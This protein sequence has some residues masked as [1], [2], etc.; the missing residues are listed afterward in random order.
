MEDTL[1][2]SD[3]Y[4]LPVPLTGPDFRELA[5]SQ[6]VATLLAS[7]SAERYLSSSFLNQRALVDSVAV[8]FHSVAFVLD[9]PSLRDAIQERLSAELP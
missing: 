8:P 3:A 9:Y 1:A 5:L 4:L 7:S 6:A 2:S